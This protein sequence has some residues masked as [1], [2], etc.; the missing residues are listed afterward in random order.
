V[1]MNPNGVLTIANAD[2]AADRA[3][4]GAAR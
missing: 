3:R 2:S 1:V 4:Y